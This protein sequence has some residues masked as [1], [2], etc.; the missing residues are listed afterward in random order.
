MLAATFTPCF[1]QFSDFIAGNGKMRFSWYR[2]AWPA[3]TQYAVPSLRFSVINPISGPQIE[4][5]FPLAAFAGTAGFR[6]EFVWEPFRQTGSAVPV[7]G[8]VTEEIS[9][10]QGKMWVCLGKYS[11][12]LIG[13]A[14]INW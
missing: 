10:N 7:N 5:K 6:I 14:Q 9:L 4:P 3:M 11:E 2:G 8:W 13:A 12:S 1:L